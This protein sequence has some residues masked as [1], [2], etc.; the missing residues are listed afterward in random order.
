MKR[1]S[2][3]IAFL[4]EF[5]ASDLPLAFARVGISPSASGDLAG[6]GDG[7]LQPP[8]TEPARK[9]NLHVLPCVHTTL[10]EVLVG[11]QVP[12]QGSVEYFGTRV[13]LFQ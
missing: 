11:Q 9:H 4:Y 3:V 13:L 1:I 12:Q 2:P 6:V 7:A 5:P 8:R 10:R